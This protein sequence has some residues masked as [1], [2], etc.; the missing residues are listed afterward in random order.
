MIIER[1]SNYYQFGCDYCGQPVTSVFYDERYPLQRGAIE[2]PE[3]LE[4]VSEETA[5]AYL[6][7]IKHAGQQRREGH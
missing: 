2:C 3:C 5:D 7:A 6:R 4:L 1:K